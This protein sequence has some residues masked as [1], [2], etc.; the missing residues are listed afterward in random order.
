MFKAYV[1]LS[2]FVFFRVTLTIFRLV[3]AGLFADHQLMFALA[4]CTSILRS[5]YQVCVVSL[6]RGSS[7]TMESHRRSTLFDE[8]SEE[9]WSMFLH[10]SFHST[11]A[12]ETKMQNGMGYICRGA[13]LHLEEYN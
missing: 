4:V 3:S 7:S 6:L 1:R 11:S 10:S 2:I 8:I 12:D 5:N 13:M 9:E